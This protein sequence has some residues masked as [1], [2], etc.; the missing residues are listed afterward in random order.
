[1]GYFVVEASCIHDYI[2]SIERH[3]EAIQAPGSRA[4]EVLSINVV[5]RPMTRTLKTIA[6]V[7]ERHSAAQVDTT[8]IECNPV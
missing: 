7:T 6:V 3:G 5:V 8:L 4:I 2:F 1:M